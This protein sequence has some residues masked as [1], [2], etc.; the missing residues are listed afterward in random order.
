MG[1]RYASTGNVVSFHFI[2]LHSVI[3]HTGDNPL[4]IEI[5]NIIE[6]YIVN[7]QRT[8]YNTTSYIYRILAIKEE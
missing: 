7:T 8:R 6:I 3:S 4:D 5:V 1:T 2:L